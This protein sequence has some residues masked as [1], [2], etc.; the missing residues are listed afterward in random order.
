MAAMLKK[1]SGQNS[2]NKSNKDSS[3]EI[4]YMKPISVSELH[5]LS[6]DFEKNHKKDT[7]SLATLNGAQSYLKQYWGF[8][9]SEGSNADVMNGKIKAYFDDNPYSSCFLMYQLAVNAREV[10]VKN[11]IPLP[12]GND[13]DKPSDVELRALMPRQV[14]IVPPNTPPNLKE[15]NQILA[16]FAS[17]QNENNV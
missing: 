1:K 10:L 14:K 6:Q 16:L 4:A 8:Y 12:Y 9:L 13:G 3:N 11:K 7:K 2:P 5:K 17:L 15:Y